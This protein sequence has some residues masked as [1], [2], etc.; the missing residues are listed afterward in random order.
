MLHWLVAVLIIVNVALA[1]SADF[2]PGE[3]R[4]SVTDTHKSI[5]I[6]VLGLA[7]LRLLWRATHRP[8]PLPRSYSRWERIGSGFAHAG[9]YLLILAL[10]ISGWLRESASRGAGHP[11]LLFGLVPWP[12]FGFIT[13]LPDPAKEQWHGLFAAAHNSFAYVLYALLALHVLGALKHQ[14]IDREPEVQRMWPAA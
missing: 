11:M 1:L 6:T 2:W 5:G 4:R 3:W 12:R 9:L 7:V 14:F 8:P 13:T 10:P